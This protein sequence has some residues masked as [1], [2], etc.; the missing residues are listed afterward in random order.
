MKTSQYKTTWL[1]ADD[2][3]APQ[4]ITVTD[5]LEEKVGSE[6]KLVLYFEGSEQGVALSKTCINQLE[7]IFKSDETDEWMGCKAT[8]FNDKSVMYEGK[9]VGGIRFRP[10]RD[11]KES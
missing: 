1:N 10:V 5:V 11:A 4:V 2:V 7:E 9:K 3:K 6:K 8:M